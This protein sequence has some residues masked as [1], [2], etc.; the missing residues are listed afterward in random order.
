MPGQ[1]GADLVEQLAVLAH[2]FAHLGQR[3][4]EPVDQLVALQDRAAQQRWVMVHTTSAAATWAAMA[5]V[6]NREDASFRLDVSSPAVSRAT[7]VTRYRRTRGATARRVRRIQISAI[8]VSN[9]AVMGSATAAGPDGE[10]GARSETTGGRDQQGPGRTAQQGGVTGHV[11]P[12]GDQRQ[13]AEDHQDHQQ[14]H[15]GPMAP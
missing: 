4:L 11:Y 3:T 10:R 12:L 2:G 14:V 1:G 5:A 13:Q 8:A 7:A 6:P 15:E 9:T